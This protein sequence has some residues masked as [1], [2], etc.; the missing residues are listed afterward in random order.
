MEIETIYGDVPSKSNCYR[1]IKRG[2]HAS[3]R[4]ADEL[5]TYEASFY[6]QCVKYRDKMVAFRDVG[7]RKE[8]L[9]QCPFGFEVDVYYSADRKDLDNSFKVVLDCLQKVRAVKND[10]KCYEIIAR[11]HIDTDNPRIEFKLYAL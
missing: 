7:K 10:N 6:R 3:L 2:N 4:K 1:I 9:K 5:Y 11:K 8:V